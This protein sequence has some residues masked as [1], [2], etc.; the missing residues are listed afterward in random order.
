MY[1]HFEDTPNNLIIGELYVCISFDHSIASSFNRSWN[2]CEKR[3][4]LHELSQWEA[5]VM[6]CFVGEI[7]KPKSIAKSN[8]SLSYRLYI[9]VITVCMY[10]YMMYIKFL[11]SSWQKCYEYMYKNFETFLQYIVYQ[12]T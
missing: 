6:L 10:M 3:A 1:F 5:I 4:G 9:K 12:F 8:T 11:S 2:V 7:V